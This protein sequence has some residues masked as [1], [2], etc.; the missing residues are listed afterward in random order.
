MA[1]RHWWLVHQCAAQKGRRYIRYTKTTFAVGGKG[2][3]RGTGKGEGK[4]DLCP[5]LCPTA[6]AICL[7]NYRGADG[8]RGELFL[9]D[10]LNFNGRAC[11]AFLKALK[12]MC[13]GGQMTHARL[14]FRPLARTHP[15]SRFG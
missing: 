5:T 3:Y 8:Q 7:S 11:K 4:D 2:V 1:G 6:R 10:A 9:C 15:E 12:P 13:Q 14:G